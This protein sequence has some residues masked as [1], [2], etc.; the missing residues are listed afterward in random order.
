[1]NQTDT[2]HRS[3]AELLAGIHDEP[4]HDAIGMRE[5]LAACG[6]CAA[7]LRALADDDA[8]IGGALA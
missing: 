5:H 2:S 1:M 3:D 7:R 6:R 8:M 4:V